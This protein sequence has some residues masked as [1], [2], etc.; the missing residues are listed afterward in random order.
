M[1]RGRLK[2]FG[3][4]RAL[5][6]DLLLVFF[7][8]A[9]LVRPL[10]RAKYLQLWSSIESTFIA[11]GRFLAAHWPHPL[12][13]PLW[14]C[15]TRF[16]YIYPPV[17][18]YGT[19]LL[20]NIFIPVK[21]YH[22]FTAIMFCLGI[23]GVYFLVRV[24]GG[25]RAQGWWSAAACALISPSF[26]FLKEMRYDAP[27]LMPVRL[28]VMVRYGEGP[29]I[30]SLSLLLFALAFAYL[31]LQRGRPRSLILAG[32]F[33]ALVTLTNF[34]GATAL[35][36]LYPVMV[37]SLWI[38][39]RDRTIWKRALAI[40]ALAYALSAFWLTPSYFRITLYNL[41]YVSQPGNQI[42]I[43][44]AIL[45]VILF[46]GGSLRWAGRKADLI[47]VT[48]ATG[49][50]LFVGLDVLGHEYFNFRIMGEPG[51]LVP[52]LDMAMILF[53][54]E[55]LRRLWIAPFQSPLAMRIARGLVVLVALGAGWT[56]RRFVRHAWEMYPKEPDYQQR[57]EYRMS[58]WMATHLPDSRTF[59]TGSVRFWWD[60]WRD[61]AE[62][63]GGSDQG[64][65]NPNPLA[66][67]WEIILGTDP[68]LATLWLQA[69]GADAVIVS[70]SHSQDVYR[71]FKYPYKFAGSLPVLFDDNAG[72]VIYRVPRRYA[73]LARVVDTAGSKAA[74]PVQS[75]NYPASLRAYSDLVERGP[76][77]PTATHWNGTDSISVH[78]KPQAGQSVL[79]QVTYDPAWR[80]YSGG[81]QLPIRPDA[82]DFMAIDAPPGTHDILLVFETPLENRI[83]DCVSALAL[84][85]CLIGGVVYS[86]GNH[87]DGARGGMSPALSGD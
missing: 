42:S 71:D 25:S 30:S 27:Y 52:E 3:Q 45:A 39:Y 15:G 10:Y 18:R 86:S 11:D 55:V 54:I 87:R 12:W 8:A 80:A 60:A 7:A 69:V 20:T 26:V 38:A 36:I 76:D 2:F 73:G 24:M 77:S 50:L 28:G 63:G 56:E 17:L 78:A 81:A 51:R 32:I 21:A 31:G 35:A 44:L 83:G 62:V 66:A 79:V 23:A 64:L 65:M 59:V 37:W 4:H 6:L 14:Y 33:S 70:D 49:S 19:A 68:D 74:Q 9:I 13:Q 47:F 48:F 22:V 5:L 53:G 57:V 72:D 61:N 16:D 67:A 46:A 41:R 84:L 29:H 40:P 82:M 85:F 1:T 58:D 43:L 34:Y 75:S